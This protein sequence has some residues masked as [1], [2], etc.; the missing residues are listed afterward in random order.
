MLKM[1]STLLGK[2]LVVVCQD[3]FKSY[4]LTGT[5]EVPRS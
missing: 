1:L 2:I 4:R 3:L 5:S